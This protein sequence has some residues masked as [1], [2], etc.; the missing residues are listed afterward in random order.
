MALQRLTRGAVLLMAGVLLAACTGGGDD[1]AAPDPTK[2]SESQSPPKGVPISEDVF[3]RDDFVWRATKVGGDD[4][5]ANSGGTGAG[6][7]LVQIACIGGSDTTMTVHQK[8]GPKTSVRCDGNVKDVIVCNKERK[9]SITFASWH[10]KPRW[11]AA[12]QLVKLGDIC[13]PLDT[14]NA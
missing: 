10:G 4:T 11:D 13:R 7:Y 14:G 5:Y 3:T 12:W 1:G 8:G 2:A 9:R 6:Q